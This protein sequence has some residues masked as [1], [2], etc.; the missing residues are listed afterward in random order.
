MRIAFIATSCTVHTRQA[1]R[2]IDDLQLGGRAVNGDGT[3]A[4]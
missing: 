3:P 2:S 1:S 4:M